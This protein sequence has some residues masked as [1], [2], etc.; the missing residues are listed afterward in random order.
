MSST[1][2]AETHLA[3]SEQR[4]IQLAECARYVL[5]PLRIDPVARHQQLIEPFQ[6]EKH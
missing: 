3:S 5:L 6:K 1:A 4:D 2:C